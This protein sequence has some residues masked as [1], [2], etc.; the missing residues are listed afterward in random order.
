MP[1]GAAYTVDRGKN[2]CVQVRPPLVEVAHPMLEAPP[3]KKRPVWRAE[4]TVSPKVNVSGSTWVLWLLVGLVYGS[5][6][7][8]VSVSAAGTGE[9]VLTAKSREEASATSQTVPGRSRLMF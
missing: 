7:I 8:R 2:P 1:G 4:T 9:A 6:L 5:L 3:S